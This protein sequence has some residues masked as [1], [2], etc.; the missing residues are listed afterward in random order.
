MNLHNLKIIIPWL[1]NNKN[2]LVTKLCNTGEKCD[3]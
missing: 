1:K 3:L 2:S